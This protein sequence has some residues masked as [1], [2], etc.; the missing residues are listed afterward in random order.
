M[1]DYELRVQSLGLSPQMEVMTFLM[2]GLN[3]SDKKSQ[4]TFLDVRNEQEVQESKLEM[5][6]EGISCHYIPCTV[7]DCEGLKQQASD[8]F[9]D[10]NAP[11]ILFCRSG[12]RAASAKKCLVDLGYTKVC[13]AGGLTD[14]N[15]MIEKCSAK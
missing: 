1:N 7:D 4:V 2:E 9:P 3:T 8:L 6:K 14:L 5:N 10:I 13:N 15:Q 12:R 11:L